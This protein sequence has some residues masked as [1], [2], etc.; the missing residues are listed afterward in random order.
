MEPIYFI[1]V[2]NLHH[3]ELFHAVALH[4]SLTQAAT[5]SCTS[6][7]SVSKQLKVF[8]DALGVR[9]FDRLPRG[10][11]LTQGGEILLEHAQAIFA[12]RDRAVQELQELAGLRRGRL[13]LAS[14]RTI[15]A[16]LLPDLLAGFMASHPAIEVA[17]E[18][19]NT[20]HC[21]ERVRAGTLEVALVE[22]PAEGDDLEIVP[23][24]DDELVFV[25]SRN[26]SLAQKNRT[27]P[28][29]RILSEPLI[30][31][32]RGSGTRAILD[33]ELLRQEVHWKPLLE[34]ESTEAIKA[35]VEAGMG[36]AVLSR[37]AVARELEHGTLV[38][39]RVPLRLERQLSLVRLR[40][41]KASRACEALLKH[42]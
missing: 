37:L 2:M 31:R 12:Q 8:E 40:G 27:V 22:G 18:V 32:E 36:I 7:S 17:V 3:L 30:A 4:G 10:I 33:R 6:Q 11:R 26:H 29:R 41:R 21:L 25:A 42:L 19:A 38:R 1:H 24:R 20:E 39:L 13:A 14:S 16:Y 35:F 5:E 28:L 15:G 34:L 9:L 23:F